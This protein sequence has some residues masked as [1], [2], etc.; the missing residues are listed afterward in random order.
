MGGRRD[1]RRHDLAAPIRG[2]PYHAYLAHA[3]R[4]AHRIVRDEAERCISWA[5]SV[6]ERPY[7]AFSCGKDSSVLAHLVLAVAPGVPLRFLSSGETR[8]MHDVDG[9]LG[10]FRA[11]GARVEETNVDR[12]FAPGWEGA[13]WD[14]QRKAGRG[15]LARLNEGHDAVFMGLRIAESP[16]R[17]RSLRMHRDREAPGFCYRYRSG[18]RVGMLRACPLSRW[19]VEDVGAYLAEH[20]IPVLHWYHAHG[21]DGRT[22]ARLTGDAARTY[23]L[24]YMARSNPDG[25]HALTDRFPELRD[26]L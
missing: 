14:E 15:D 22:T 18:P 24:S 25:V 5:L 16:A 8:L 20:S 1:A 2:A 4:P 21:L 6:S 12:V 26:F 19:S 9:V 7:V 13:T 11:R 3:R 23:A 17:E 10:W